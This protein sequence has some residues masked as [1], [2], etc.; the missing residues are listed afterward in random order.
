MSPEGGYRGNGEISSPTIAAREIYEQIE[1]ESVSDVLR[2][3]LARAPYTA[4]GYDVFAV[5]MH[6]AQPP[7]T[8]L[9]PRTA[10]LLLLEHCEDASFGGCTTPVQSLVRR[11]VSAFD[12]DSGAAWQGVDEVEGNT[13][14]T[15]G[16]L[17]QAYSKDNQGQHFML[18]VEFVYADQ[19]QG[20]L[21]DEETLRVLAQIHARTTL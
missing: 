4:W 2:I 21:V 14:L 12:I 11:T 13:F 9:D 16:R 10:R 15:S 8:G 1:T 20:R 6:G 17:K 7:I 3:G 19:G 18:Q 5:E